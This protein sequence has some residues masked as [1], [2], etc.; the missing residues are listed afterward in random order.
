MGVYIYKGEGV[1][2]AY[3]ISFFLK[4]GGG[5]EE[6]GSSESSEPPLDPPLIYKFWQQN[7]YVALAVF[8]RI[9]S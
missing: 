3:F 2:F 5:V 1:R 4:G 8:T 7:V 9:A 6:W